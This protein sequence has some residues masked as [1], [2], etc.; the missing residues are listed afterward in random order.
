MYTITDIDWGWKNK[1]NTFGTLSDGTVVSVLIDEQNPENILESLP[2]VAVSL[3]SMVPDKAAYHGSPS[4][5]VYYITSGGVP[6]KEVTMH[7]P[8]HYMLQYKISS[9]ATN[10]IHDRELMFKLG[11][12]LTPNIELDLDVGIPNLFLFGE[13][14]YTQVIR[15]KQIFV[16][17]TSVDKDQ[18]IFERVWLY[19]IHAEF[20][21]TQ[22]L[23]VP[24]ITEITF[25][26]GPVS[27]IT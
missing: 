24:V 9:L 3:I 14:F 5:E 4:S 18:K 19:I 8:E 7:Q 16:D 11:T 2:A 15:D 27:E 1:L 17:E 10:P 12:I 21:Q 22:R 6:I 25:N 20:E 26:G 23:V 13:Q